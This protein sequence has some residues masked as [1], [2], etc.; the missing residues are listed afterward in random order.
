MRILCL[1]S[2]SSSLK[3]ALYD[4]AGDERRLTSGERNVRG[5]EQTAAAVEQAFAS[6][7]S[8][9]ARIDAV[10]HRLVFGGIAHDAPARVDAALLARLRSLTRF[11]PLH[12]PAGIA[13]ID[14]ALA[15]APHIPHVACFDSAFHRRMPEAAERL[16]LDRALWDEGVRRIG[17]HGLSYEYVVQAI[18][19]G[20]IGRGVIAHLGH[21]A[22]M[23]AV[24]DGVSVD[25]TMGFTPTG[26]FM[27][28]TRSGD[29][30]PGVI[31][32]LLRDKA[33]DAAALED[34]VV[35]EGGLLAVSGT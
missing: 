16:P 31:L 26:G 19:A 24:R 29:L 12:M 27:M 13:A 14:A 20:A 2:G 5:E 21:G 32:Y 23:A 33:M 4:I 35:R 7:A 8:D 17:F 10:G 25:T 30:D 34:F 6:A 3:F 15:H 1:N 22:S 18:G 28:S 11:A 9:G